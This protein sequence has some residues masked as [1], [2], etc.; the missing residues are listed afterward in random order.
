VELRD[1]LEPLFRQH[2]VNVVLSGHEHFYERIHPQNGIYYFISGAAGQLRYEN[3]RKSDITAKGYAR[4]RH[5][6]I[7]EIKKDEFHFQ[8]IAR[9]G[10]TVDSGCLQRIATGQAGEG[11]VTRSGATQ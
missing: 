2:D 7:V 6:M 11:A 3:I 4:D 8:V 9:S 5:F 10:E 1:V